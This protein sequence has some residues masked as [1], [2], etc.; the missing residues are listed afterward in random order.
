MHDRWTS[1]VQMSI[2]CHYNITPKFDI[3]LST[4][5]DLHLGKEVDADLAKD[6]S[7]VINEHSNAGWE[8]HIMFIISVHYKLIKLWKP[9]G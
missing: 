7:L 2:G 8:G 5:Y 9:K 4:L 1:A 6:G 3:S